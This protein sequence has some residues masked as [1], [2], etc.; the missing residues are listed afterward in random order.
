MVSFGSIEHCMTSAPAVEV[1]RTAN[2]RTALPA[3][4]VNPER[5][6]MAGNSV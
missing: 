5:S 1:A 2:A 4:V 3:A 6:I